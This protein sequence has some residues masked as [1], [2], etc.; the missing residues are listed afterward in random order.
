MNKSKQK[1][2]RKEINQKSNRKKSLLSHALSGLFTILL[3]GLMVWGY[4]CCNASDLKFAQVSDVHFSTRNV[5]TT[6]K[7][8]AESPQLLDDAINQINEIPDINFVMFTGDLI[9]KPF[10]QE[11][12]AV[13]PHVKNLKYPW[14]FAFGNHDPCVGGYLTKKLYLEILSENNT[15]KFTQPYYSF[16]PQKGYKII[17]LDSIIDTRITSN[18]EIYPEQVK[19]LEEELDKSKKDVVLIFMHVPIIEP[20]PSEG[21]RLLNAGEIMA[22]LEKHKNPIAVF[23]GHYHANKIT[24]HDNVLYVSSPALV[25]YPN[26]FRIITIKNE[27]NKVIFDIQQKDVGKESLRSL[28]KMMAFSSKLYTGEPKDQNGIYEIKKNK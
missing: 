18:G 17:V 5:N 26:A 13:L 20:F 14:Y 21:H 4:E 3:A 24:Q 15:F 6:F 11:L 28:A 8:T 1:R 16:S 23:Q 25:S 22:L 27:K 2:I 12:Q 7:L 9:D 19:W 10:E